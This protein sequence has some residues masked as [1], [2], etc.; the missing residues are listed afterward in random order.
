MKLNSLSD[1]EGEEAESL[2]LQ[3]DRSALSGYMS[4]AESRDKSREYREYDR[5]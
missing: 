2:L 1:D 3:R 4:G 5:R